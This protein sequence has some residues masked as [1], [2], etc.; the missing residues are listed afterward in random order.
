MNK[1]RKWEKEGP[2]R[3][4]DQGRIPGS[5]DKKIRN[6]ENGVDKVR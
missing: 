1:M 3:G 6:Q 4:V 2:H 5:V